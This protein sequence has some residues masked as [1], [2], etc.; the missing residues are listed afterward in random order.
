MPVTNYPI[1]KSAKIKKLYFE[2]YS[3]AILLVATIAFIWMRTIADI[4]VYAYWIVTIIF[5]LS[6]V[7][8]IVTI[9]LNHYKI[10]FKRGKF[11]GN[12]TLNKNSVQMVKEI[13]PIE[14][15]ESIHFINDDFFIRYD[16]NK[17]IG[18]KI[19]SGVGNVCTLKTKEGKL[20]RINFYQSHDN[21]LVK[22]EVI[23]RYYHSKK[24]LSS[25]NLN[26]ILNE[27]KKS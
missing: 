13:I 27:S 14:N 5:I 6:F 2:F 12:L 22:A 4:N 7:P 15:I 1:F 23:L 8:L 24:I 21:E 17:W 26:Q 18:P 9:I 11:I 19:S 20:Y 16:R 25:E 10:D 3:L